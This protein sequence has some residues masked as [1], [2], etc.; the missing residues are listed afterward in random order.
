MQ[1][2]YIFFIVFQASK[3]NVC[4]KE[5]RYILKFYYKKGKNA[6]NAANKISAVYRPNAVSIRVAQMWFKRLKSGNF[7][8]KDEVRSGRPVTDK[9]RED[10]F[11]KVE[12]VRHIS[13]YDIAEKLDVDHKT[14]LCLC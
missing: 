12:Q 8:V 5:I 11:E 13:S 14:V 2:I 1:Q 9:I 7:C 10:H 6:T 4:D 3:M